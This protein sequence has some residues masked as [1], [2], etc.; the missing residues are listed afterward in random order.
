ML[1]VF[2]TDFTFFFDKILRHP[3]N[4]IANLFGFQEAVFVNNLHSFFD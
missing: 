3:K 2:N 4:R 1:D